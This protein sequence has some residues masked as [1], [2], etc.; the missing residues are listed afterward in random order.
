MEKSEDQFESPDLKYRNFRVK[1]KI[2]C[3]GHNKEV[4]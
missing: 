1:E 2:K 3:G 4:I